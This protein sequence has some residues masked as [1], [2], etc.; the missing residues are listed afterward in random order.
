MKRVVTP[1]I[2]DQLEPNDPAALH[3][4]RD[5]RR[6]NWLMGNDRW[7]RRTLKRVVNPEDSLLELGAGAGD[8]GLYL[9]KN[10]NLSCLSYAGL[11]LWPRPSLWPEHW[12]WHQAD[13]T[14]FSNYNEYTVLCGNFILHQF[15]DAVLRKLFQKILPHLRALIFCETARRKLHLAQLPLSNL[16]GIN[17]VSRHDARVSIEG[18]FYDQELPG[19]LCLNPDEWLIETKMTFLGAY[20]LVAIR[21]S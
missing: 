8:F 21:K 6:F 19:L 16:M 17:Y 14:D 12:A 5:L 11:D 7:M 3:N 20:R 13:L 10:Q 18:G 9:H 15:R 2:L 4:R 1:E